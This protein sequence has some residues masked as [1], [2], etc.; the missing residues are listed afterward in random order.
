MSA[1]MTNMSE[2]QR[3]ARKGVYGEMNRGR[4]GEERRIGQ[5]D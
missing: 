3:R 2:R 5:V 4:A 1:V